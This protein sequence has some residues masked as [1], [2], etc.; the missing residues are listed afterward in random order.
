MNHLKKFLPIVLL[1]T[2]TLL[3]ILFGNLTKPKYVPY[4]EGLV[5]V[6][7]HSEAGV[8][9]VL[10]HTSA[11]NYQ[12]KTNN[13]GEYNISLYTTAWDDIVKNKNAITN[14]TFDTTENEVKSIYYV[15]CDLADDVLLYGQSS[16]MGNRVSLPNLLLASIMKFMITGTLVLGLAILLFCRLH[17][18][19]CEFLKKL[20]L[21]PISWLLSQLFITGFDPST[22]TPI[23]DF[24]MILLLAT[25]I[26]L[27]FLTCSKMVTPKIKSEDGEE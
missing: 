26:F 4:G 20:I 12:L 7:E 10:F 5:E 21:I 25:I 2:F 15:S 3:I 9:N 8:I 24:G 16:P 17:V 1:F 19:I 22:F 23:R 13:Q 6:T 18:I 27:I 14:I 11:T